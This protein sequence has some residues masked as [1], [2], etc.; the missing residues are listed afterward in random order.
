MWVCRLPVHIG[1]ADYTVFT[2]IFGEFVTSQRAD[3]GIGPYKRGGMCIWIRRRYSQN[4]CVPCWAYSFFSPFRRISDNPTRTRNPPNSFRSR[5]ASSPVAAQA[6][7]AAQVR[8][9]VMQGSK[10]FFST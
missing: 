3:V 4:S 8:P 9:A 5:L 1:P 7:R 2:E 6:H 10:A